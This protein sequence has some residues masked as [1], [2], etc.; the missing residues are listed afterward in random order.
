LWTHEYDP[1]KAGTL[2]V[3]C[4]KQKQKRNFQKIGQFEITEFSFASFILSKAGSKSPN[5]PL[6]RLLAQKAGAK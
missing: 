3:S 4:Q 2:S 1:G 6:S 5:F